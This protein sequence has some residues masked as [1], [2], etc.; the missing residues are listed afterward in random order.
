MF[1][2][3]HN[4]EHIVARFLLSIDDTLLFLTTIRFLQFCV[5]FLQIDHRKSFPSSNLCTNRINR[6]CMLSLESTKTGLF[7]Q[8]VVGKELNQCNS[9][10]FLGGSRVV[11]R[12]EPGRNTLCRK[13]SVISASCNVL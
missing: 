4:Y 11:S 12:P 8:L 13:S 3:H 9:W 2:F 10:N 1:L 7:G 6:R 5:C